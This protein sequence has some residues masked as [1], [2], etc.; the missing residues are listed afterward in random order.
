M[1]TKLSNNKAE[2]AEFINQVGPGTVAGT[3]E[4]IIDRV[5][6]FID[7]GVDEIMFSPRPCDSEALQRLDEEIITAFG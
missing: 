5:G 4:Y 7:V 1:P 6:E 2:V 3:A